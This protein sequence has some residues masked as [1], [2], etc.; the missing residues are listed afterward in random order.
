MKSLTAA[1]LINRAGLTGLVLFLGLVSGA[2]QAA[3]GFE[4]NLRYLKKNG[5]ENV[6]GRSVDE[7]IE[8]GRKVPVIV[9]ETS[10][11]RGS[12]GSDRRS[13]QWGEGG[14]VLSSRHLLNMGEKH[15][16]GIWTHEKCQQIT[17]GDCDQNYRVSAL[18]EA[19]KAFEGIRAKRAGT[20]L[21]M[22]PVPLKEFS[23]D[24]EK[25]APSR[26]R[27]KSGG[28]VTGIGGGGDMR[29][30]EFLKTVYLYLFLEISR[31]RLS[32]DEFHPIY[33]LLGAF[34]I[35]FH[36]QLP[37][38]KLHIANDTIYI[39]Q[40]ALSGDRFDVNIMAVESLVDALIKV[41]KGKQ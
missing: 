24:F 29:G 13:G 17:R 28:G 6:A 14:V 10:S 12:D 18:I 1:H 7:L 33:E 20:D 27:Q 9:T 21:E 30:L 32:Y 4:E 34:D 16:S 38:G 22:R 5:V 39:P 15:H 11:Y 3:D 25:G 31:E 2:V 36:S 23:R 26:D 37:Q 19:H 8:K 40:D 35:Q 41:A